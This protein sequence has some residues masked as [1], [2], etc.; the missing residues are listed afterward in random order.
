M[1]DLSKIVGLSSVM[2]GKLVLLQKK[3]EQKGKQVKLCNV[4]PELREVLAAMKL[5]QILQIEED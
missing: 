4:G 3:M 1:L 5:D 2:L